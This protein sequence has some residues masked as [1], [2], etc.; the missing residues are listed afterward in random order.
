MTAVEETSLADLLDP[1][2]GRS[3]YDAY[4]LLRDDAP[5][6]WSDSLDAWLVARYGDVKSILDSPQ[7]FASSQRV[8]EP[9]KPTPEETRLWTAFAGFT[10]FFWSDPPEYT[11][12]RKAW[13]S[14]LRPRLDGIAA[15]V[16]RIVDELLDEAAA[17][18]S[19]D[20]VTDLA[21][22]LPATVVFELLGVPLD[23]RP[24]FRRIA[25]GLI[26]LGEPAAASMEE[27]SAWL[28]GFM[29][30]RQ[31]EPRDDMLSD[32]V[33]LL[34]PLD[35]LTDQQIRSET[36]NIVHFLLAGHE[37]TT[38]AIAS[39]MLA[40]L[41]RPG[42]RAAI[43][44]DDV[45]ETA[46]EEILRYESPLQYVDRRAVGDV[47]LHGRTIAAGQT[48]KALIGS[49]N[50]DER[51]FESPDDFDIRRRPNRHVA[52]GHNIH[53]CLGAPLARVEI[54]IAISSTLRRF[55]RL[56]LGLEPADVR[57]RQSLMFR[58]IEEL[59]LERG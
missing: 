25:A 47:E 46:V 15:R 38:S 32:L 58:T 40:L 53:F 37:T 4:R 5:V 52:F 48:V 43:E 57:W 3:P 33:R 22:P 16:R 55:P 56:R 36:V 29:Y 13:T 2:D 27:A 12:H 19:F 14:A 31:A 23:D 24:V 11:E 28:R 41:Q 50:R 18:Q 51:Q 17:K 54:P 20:L 26:A 30:E 59:P 9:A 8:V 42:D 7:A 1:G 34:P 39:G 35:E 44:R 21:F 49:A 6:C 45:L 10:G